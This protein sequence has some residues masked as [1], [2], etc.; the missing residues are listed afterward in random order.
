MF[1]GVGIGKLDANVIDREPVASVSGI[2]AIKVFFDGRCAF[3][4]VSLGFR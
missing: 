3:V 4:D 1:I 2:S